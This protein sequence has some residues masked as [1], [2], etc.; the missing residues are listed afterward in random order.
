[1]LVM[2]NVWLEKLIGIDF[3]A[4]SNINAVEYNRVLYSLFEQTDSIHHTS[5][6]LLKNIGLL[7][8]EIINIL[9]SWFITIQ[10]KFFSS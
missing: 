3:H 1:M 7:F 5:D 9:T 2:P 8:L 4:L 6:I 10:F